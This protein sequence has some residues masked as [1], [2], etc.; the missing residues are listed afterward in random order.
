[1]SDAAVVTPEM[2]AGLPTP[3]Q[4]YMNFS[5]VVGR[6][7]V[8]SVIVKQTGRIRLGPEKRWMQLRAT[9]SYSVDPPSFTWDARVGY[10]RLSLL[11]VRD[12]Y[13]DGKGAVRVR[14]A[15]LLQLLKAIGPKVDDSSAVRVLSE[16]VW[17]P[18]AFLGKNFI[19]TAIDDCSAQVSFAA[20]GRSVSGRFHF[21][22]MAGRRTLSLNATK[23][24]VILSRCF[25]QLRPP[26]TEAFAVL[27]CQA[28]VRQSGTW[29][30]EISLTSISGSMR[31]PMTRRAHDCKVHHLPSCFLPSCA[32]SGRATA[33]EAKRG[34]RADLVRSALA[35]PNHSA[36]SVF[37]KRTTC[38]QA[39]RV[40]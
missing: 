27:P 36:G 1:V 37:V 30:R 22:Q 5:G 28:E 11:A 29:S 4:R 24:F 8:K 32:G 15:N 26:P 21:A 39:S 13:V 35:V 16:V 23:M 18:S 12:S 40:A 20:Y 38:D 33:N 7:L 6:P 2:L 9:E 14:L 19:W 25:G 31:S 10:G 34:A 17:F 3:V